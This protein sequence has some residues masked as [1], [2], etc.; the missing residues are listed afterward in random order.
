MGISQTDVDA[1]MAAAAGL[2]SQA[3]AGFVQDHRPAAQS[4]PSRVGAASRSGP[5]LSAASARDDLQ[6]ILQVSVPV[7]VKLASQ[8]MPVKKVLQFK[9]GSIIEFDQAFDSDLELIVANRLIGLGQ[10]VKVGENFGLRIN[11][12][13]NIANTIEALGGR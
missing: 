4:P 13:G 12:I 2:V 3:G 11:K 7:M 1:L 10:A 5:G 9:P 6:R 8:E